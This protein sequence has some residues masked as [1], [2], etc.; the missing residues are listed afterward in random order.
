MHGS[1]RSPAR[2]SPRPARHL[3]Q[4]LEGA[5][6]R[7]R[8]GG[9]QAQIAI[10][11]AHEGKQR[12]IVP[13]R[14]E[15]RA[16]DNIGLAR[17]DAREDSRNAA[18]VGTRSLDSTQVRASGQRFFTSSS[19][20]SMPGP[21]AASTPSRLQAGHPR[22]GQREAAM[23]ADQPRAGGAQRDRRCIAGR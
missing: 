15:L 20:R 6:A 12:E 22:E 10:D 16:H 8:I 18:V 11:H 21:E 1:A 5:L 7:A 2:Q 4:Q 14:D 13:L 17:R 9:G 3:V 23:M 19:T